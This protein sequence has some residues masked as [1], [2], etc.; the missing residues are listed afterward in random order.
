MQGVFNERPSEPKY[1]EIWDI[2][3]VLLHLESMADLGDLSFKELTLK[4]VMLMALSNA[5]R[6]S[7]LD[8]LDLR[9]M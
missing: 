3:E 9:Y 2:D 8:L 6:A 1:S 7:D 5:D 4:T